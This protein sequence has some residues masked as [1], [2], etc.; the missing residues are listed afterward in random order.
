MRPLCF[1]LASFLGTVPLEVVFTAT[2]VASERFPIC[3]CGIVV[4]LPSVAIIGSTTKASACRFSPPLSFAFAFEICAH[5]VTIPIRRAHVAALA[6][7]LPN[8][9]SRSPWG[10]L[11]E[12]PPLAFGFSV[13]PVGGNFTPFRL[14]FVE[15][16][17]IYLLIPRVAGCFCACA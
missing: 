12:A 10:L 1:E 17:E 9:A 14:D 3:T 16:S 13:L 4:S 5:V 15:V 2:F 11:R 7:S 8:E 6:S